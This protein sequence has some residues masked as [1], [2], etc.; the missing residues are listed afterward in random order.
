MAMFD[1]VLYALLRTYVQKSLIGAGAIK[2]AS[3]QILSIERNLTDDGTVVTFKYEDNA[4]GVHTSTMNVPD[5]IDGEKGDKGDKGDKGNTGERGLDG[6]AGPAGRT[7]TVQIGS[8]TSGEIA[9]IEN[10]GTNNDAVFNFVLPKGEKGDKGANGEDGQDGKSFDIKGQYPT[11]AA[12]IAA[13]PTGDAGEAYF[14]GTD[15]NPDLYIWLTD[16]Q[17]W[18]NSGK[19][20]GIKGDKGDT[21]EDGFSPIASVSK[22]GDTTTVI[23]RDKTGQTSVQIKDGEK[24]DPGVGEPVFKGTQAQWDGLTL[25]QKLEYLTGMVVI[26][27]DYDESDYVKREEIGTAAAKNATDKVEPGNH[28]LV[29]S[30]AVSS[31]IAQAIST[32]FTPHGNLTCAELLPALLIAANVGNLY[33]MTDSGTTTSDF[34]GGAGQTIN[35]GDTVGIITTGPSEYKFNLMPGLEDLSQY[36]NVF[37][38]YLNPTDGKFYKEVTYTTEIPGKADALFVNVIDWAQYAYDETNMA[39]VAVG[40]GS[41]IFPGTLDEWNVLTPAEKAKYDFI[42]SPEEADITG[43]YS[44]TETKTGATW[45]DGKPIYRRT[46]AVTSPNTTAE[47]NVSIAELG[48]TNIDKMFIIPPSYIY[49]YIN[50]LNQHVPITLGWGSGD[51]GIIPSTDDSHNGYLVWK[52]GNS[53]WTSKNGYVTLMYTKTTD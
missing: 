44:T 22:T 36:A 41:G 46:I 13:H 43:S 39:Y 21:G 26:N 16:D 28:S 1:S 35:V 32:V 45:I 40:G 2:G 12:L 33:N 8:V 49:L 19:I 3:C 52:V 29:E 42:A 23:I 48:F 27:D 4:G 25:E 7:A 51:L 11:Y 15:N 6:A 14:V 31:A 53:A 18:H 20:A 34:V 47:T 38:G 24:G 17:V 37:Y 9:S 10:V 5:G 50:N 30:N